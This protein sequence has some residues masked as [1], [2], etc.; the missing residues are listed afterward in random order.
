MTESSGCFWTCTRNSGH[1][2]VFTLAYTHHMELSYVS[3]E[4]M[5]ERSLSY[6]LLLM[7]PEQ[8]KDCHRCSYYMCTLFCFLILVL[9][10]SMYYLLF[11]VFEVLF[12][13]VFLWLREEVL[14]L[15]WLFLIVRMD[16]SRLFVWEIC[17]PFLFSVRLNMNG[18]VGS[19]DLFL[20]WMLFGFWVSCW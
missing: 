7:V 2:L 12:W 8:A 10:L 4:V 18:F 5:I 19:L 16:N 13:E 9:S 3:G 20:F 11:S 14:S 15:F 6:M 1:T 17:V